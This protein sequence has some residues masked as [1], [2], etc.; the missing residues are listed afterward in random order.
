MLRDG[1]GVVNATTSVGASSLLGYTDITS[2]DR[3]CY[4]LSAACDIKKQIITGSNDTSQSTHTMSN[5]VLRKDGGSTASLTCLSHAW[6]LTRR[7]NAEVKKHV[8]MR[9]SLVREHMTLIGWGFLPLI[10]FIKLLVGSKLRTA[11]QH[12]VQIST[13][14]TA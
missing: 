2:E 13:H 6:C 1:V 8:M 5:K 4:L 10:E 3:V 14:S 9:R 12:L 7:H 11:R